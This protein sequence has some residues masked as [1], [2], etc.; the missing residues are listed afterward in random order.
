MPR[1]VRPPGSAGLSTKPPSQRRTKVRAIS[2]PSVDMAALPDA[3]VGCGRCI[4][5]GRCLSRCA[6]VLDLH[7][8]VVFCKSELH[9]TGSGRSTMD[10]SATTISDF[11]QRV[12]LPDIE[13]SYEAV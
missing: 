12:A 1:F 6:L 8:A 5:F 10:V 3:C 13:P 11:V 4:F 7:S 2:I 9:V